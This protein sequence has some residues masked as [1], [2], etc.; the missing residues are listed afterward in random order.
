MIH[1]N[2]NELI[3]KISKFYDKLNQKRDRKSPRWMKMYWNQFKGNV[4]EIGS[5]TLVP[6]KSFDISTYLVAGISTTTVKMLKEKGI[7]AI[8]AN[9]ENL[10]FKNCTFDTVACHDVLELHTKSRKIYRRDVSCFKRPSNYTG[11]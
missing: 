3:K 2:N 8:V 10:T 6:D 11:T 9:G 7:N 1:N 4:L 5:G